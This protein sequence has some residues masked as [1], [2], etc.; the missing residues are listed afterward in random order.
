MV[1]KELGKKRWLWL[2]GFEVQIELQLQIDVEGP[3]TSENQTQTFIHNIISKRLRRVVS[4]SI[5]YIQWL[6]KYDCF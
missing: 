3:E 2:S 1:E 5:H 6:L 4:G